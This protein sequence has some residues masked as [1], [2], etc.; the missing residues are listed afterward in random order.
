MPLAGF[1]DLCQC[2]CE[3][4]GFGAPC[5]VPATDGARAATMHLR[6]V[7]ITAVELPAGRDHQAFL[8]AQL[9]APGDSDDEAAA[10]W[11]TLLDA[12]S[13]LPDVDSPRFSRN[14]LSGDIT[15]QWPCALQ[16]I[17]PLDAYQRASHMADVVLHWQRHRRVHPE[18]LS[19][20]RGATGGVVHDG[21]AALDAAWRFREL[22]MALC[23][24]LGQSAQPG[25]PSTQA[26]SFSLHFDDVEVVMA[27]LPR[28]RPHAM[29]VGVPLGWREPGEQANA[30]A[31]AMMDAN[32]ALAEQPHGAAFCRDPAS[33]ELLLRYAYPLDGACV[34]HCLAQ[35]ASL[36]G[37]AR[38]WIA[39]FTPPENATP[40]LDP[41]L[42]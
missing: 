35:M 28:L 22:Y 16:D 17:S 19:P 25:P 20:G 23:D 42:V 29:L 7:A 2:I 15:M 38:D 26:F 1:E 5:L 3:L 11:L 12:N 32:F 37:F 8:T 30:E 9:D 33:G 10:G 13:V 24:V 40:R 27:H 21:A 18:L 41:A 14:P 39:S 6:G 31:M 34:R 36:A 4:A